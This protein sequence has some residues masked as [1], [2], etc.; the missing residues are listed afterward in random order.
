MGLLSRLLYPNGSNG[1][2]YVD[3]GLSVNWATMN[4]DARA[5]YECGA[6]V[7]WGHVRLDKKPHAQYKV[8]VGGDN[9]TT[10]LPK[11]DIAHCKM[12][13]NWRIPTIEESDELLHQCQWQK[14]VINH[15]I[16]CF[17]ITGP[18]NNHIILP[19]NGEHGSAI[20]WTSSLNPNN[21]WAYCLNIYDIFERSL[22]PVTSGCCRKDKCMVRGV[23]PKNQ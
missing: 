7:P 6:V 15:A 12:G 17:K 23:L 20:Y 9:I 1:H 11:D 5:S 13:G 22:Q 10:L 21:S 4:V 16:H 2:E 14:I 19:L 3:L 18:N 8:G